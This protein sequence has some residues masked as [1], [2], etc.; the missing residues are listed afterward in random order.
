MPPPPPVPP[1]SPVLM[2][3]FVCAS[4]RVV[5]VV[6]DADDVPILQQQGGVLPDGAAALRGRAHDLLLQVHQVQTAVE[7]VGTAARCCRCRRKSSVFSCC[8]SG[9]LCL[10][11]K[12]R[13]CTLPCVPECFCCDIFCVL[14]S[15][16]RIAIVFFR[17]GHI[18]E[19]CRI[20]VLQQSRNIFFMPVFVCCCRASR[21][22]STR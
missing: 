18:H 10:W 19:L 6:W 8:V 15:V 4:S 11:V 9:F 20:Y 1:L 5:N 14:L 21:T 22:G 7:G 16:P 13:V 2:H 3:L 12:S 17:H